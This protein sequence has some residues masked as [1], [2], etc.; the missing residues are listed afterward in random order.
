MAS[1]ALEI[2]DSPRRAA[3]RAGGHRAC[4]Q[5]GD[6]VTVTTAG[7]IG[8][9]LADAEP[10]TRRLAVQQ[11]VQVRGPEAAPLLVQAL[12]DPDWRVRKEATTIASSIESRES[13]L[14][15]LRAALGDRVNLGLRNAAVEALV[16]HGP[17]RA[18][19]GDGSVRYARRRRAKARGRGAHRRARHARHRRAHASL[20]R[21]G[22]QRA[23][24][25]GRGAG[26]RERGRGRG[27][28]D[29]D[30]GSSQRAL[31]GRDGA[32]ARCARGADSARGEALLADRGGLREATPS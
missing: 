16:A 10:E 25:G 23:R 9:L 6:A 32:Q 14:A 8:R 22:P 12:G 20:A 24:R 30:H 27:A 13:V 7:E 17:R 5:V 19:D 26:A 18:A 29:R 21:R 2:V 28:T 4:S 15:A 1:G 3:R 11:L 31:L